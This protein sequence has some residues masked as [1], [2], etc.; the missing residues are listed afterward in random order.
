MNHSDQPTIAY[1]LKGFPRNSEAFITNE[2]LGLE[3]LGMKFHIFSAFPGDIAPSSI[4]GEIRSRVTYLPE[5]P[6]SMNR[7]FLPWLKTNLPLYLPSHRRLFRLRPI[8]YGR[9]MLKAIRLSMTCP[10]QSFPWIKKAFYK[11]FLRAGFIACKILEAGSIRHL[12]AHF[13]HGSTTMA[14]FA[15]LL[16]DIPYSFTAHAKDIYLSR[17]NPGNLLSIKM[18]EAAFVVTCTEANLRHLEHLYPKASRK[19][20]RVYHGV[21]TGRFLPK[22]PRNQTLPVI[23]SVG[24]HVK[25]KGFPYLI[26]ACAILKERGYLFRCVILGEPDEETTCIR[27]LIATHQL[28]EIVELQ[29]G[30]TQEALREIYH[31]ATIFALACHIV[32][33][34]DRDGIPNVLAEAMASG[35]PVVSTNIS[36]IPELIT[37]RKDGLLVPQKNP[38]ALAESLEALLINPRFQTALSKGGREKILQLFCA[39]ATIKALANLFQ[40]QLSGAQETST[41]TLSIP[42]L[43]D[44]NLA[45]SPLDDKNGRG[46]EVQRET[47]DLPAHR[48]WLITS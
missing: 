29:P 36:G 35:L 45:T 2:I 18:Q 39:R 4:A 43:G 14:L 21:D 33:N 31:R 48:K 25:K 9:V 19:I 34:G 26:Q 22:P 47:P 23:L 37:H 32:E 24:R 3:A 13:C 12:H 30:L 20:Y 42:R 15:G 1:I 28:E 10:S 41:A 8:A 5:A 46:E 40:A 44:G 27:T 6:E 17:L 38:Q 7:P 11:D 16:T